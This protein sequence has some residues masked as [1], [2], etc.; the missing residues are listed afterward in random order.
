MLSP[1]QGKSTKVTW[2][3]RLSKGGATGLKI[4]VKT[5]ESVAEV[6]DL[7]GGSV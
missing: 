6:T 2:Y 4:T 1:L 5:F 7:I 3:V